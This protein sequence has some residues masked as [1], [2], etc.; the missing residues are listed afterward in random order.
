MP[1]SWF[2]V[3]RGTSEKLKRCRGNDLSDGK[4][5]NCVHEILGEHACRAVEFKHVGKGKFSKVRIQYENAE[6]KRKIREDLDAV[7]IP[8]ADAAKDE[9]EH[10]DG[11]P[12]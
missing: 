2:R 6:H 1:L 12:G 8:D 4:F 7:E 11:P 5:E 10:P 9:D 3:P